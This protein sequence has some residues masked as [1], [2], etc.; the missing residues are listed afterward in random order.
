[1]A[2]SSLRCPN[3]NG[4]VSDGCRG[5]F[6]LHGIHADY[7]CPHC[8]A[9]L[10]WEQQHPSR[11]AF[12]AFCLAILVTSLCIAGWESLNQQVRVLS[13]LIGNGLVALITLVTFVRSLADP[14]EFVMKTSEES[15]ACR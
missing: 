3:C 4:E 2:F 14:W 9:V 10:E 1:M 6:P 11:W 7:L 8:E 12:G 5:E 13:L 15:D